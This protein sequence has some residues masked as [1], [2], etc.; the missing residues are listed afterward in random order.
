MQSSLPAK[1]TIAVAKRKPREVKHELTGT[2]LEDDCE[3]DAIDESLLNMNIQD[4]RSWTDDEESILPIS[5]DESRYGVWA[6]I[7]SEFIIG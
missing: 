6:N 3:I 1:T 4:Y 7:Q 5:L 2:P